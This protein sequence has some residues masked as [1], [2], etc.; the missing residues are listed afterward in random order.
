M[1]NNEQKLLGNNSEVETTQNV[2]QLLEFANKIVK[3]KLTPFTSGEQ[4]LVA[5][6]MGRELGLPTMTSLN[7]I[8]VINGKPSLGVHIVNAALSNKGVD[9]EVI[10]DVEPIFQTFPVND[11][12]NPVSERYVK[13]LEKSGY[14][15]H[16]IKY[17]GT[18]ENMAKQKQDALAKYAD[19]TI[20]GQIPKIVDY[21]CEIRFKRIHP[22][23]KIEKEH[24]E[25][26]Y[27][28][29]I[30]AS[31]R[32]KDNWNNYMAVMLRKQTLLNGGRFFAPDALFGCTETGEMLDVLGISYNVNADGT[33]ESA[34]TNNPNIIIATTEEV[35]TPTDVEDAEIVNGE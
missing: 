14:P 10:R 20:F 12:E 17:S 19:K 16:I 33:V 31:I 7:N 3:S 5:I 24:T 18:A 26:L 28:T 2:N 23:T 30:P 15:I 29:D 13:L 22:I 6:L 34:N 35:I 4:A 25:T 8:S 27:L 9:V 11:K 1:S 21:V 32:S